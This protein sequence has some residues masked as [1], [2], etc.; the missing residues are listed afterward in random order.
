[1]I[2]EN[3]WVPSRVKIVGVSTS[4]WR[5]SNALSTYLRRKPFSCSLVKTEFPTTQVML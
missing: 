1:V 2:G 4:V 3:Y 5:I